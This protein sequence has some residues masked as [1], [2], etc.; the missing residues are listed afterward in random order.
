M[1]P[2]EDM[3]VRSAVEFQGVMLGRHEEELAAAHQAVRSLAH[4][5]T[6]LSAHLLHLHQEPSSS[7][8]RQPPPVGCW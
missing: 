4:Q 5:V 8:T 6:Y 1:D 3:P 7:L 2:A